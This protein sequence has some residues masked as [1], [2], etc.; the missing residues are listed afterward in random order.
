[1][2]LGVGDRVDAWTVIS[3]D[4]SGMRAVC[5]CVCSTTRILSIRALASGD[6]APSCGCQTLTPAQ[7]WQRHEAAAERKRQRNMK[8]WKPGK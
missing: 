3:I 6:V 5:M 4:P 1:M 7:E 8:D 2:T